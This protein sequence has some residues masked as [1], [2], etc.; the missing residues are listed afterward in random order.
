MTELS[1][2][3]SAFLQ[4]HLPCDRN[5]SCN[6][7]ASYAGSWRQLVVF[8]SERLCIRPHRIQVEQITAPLILDFLDFLQCQC[9]NGAR[10]RNIRL[11]A[12]KSIFSL[13]RISNSAMPGPFP[14]GACHTRQ[15]L[16]SETD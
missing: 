5:V 4:Q 7:I 13:P 14:A 15:T 1:I 16:R 12:I 11:A 8:P 3:L 6:T 10:T 2:H 9:G